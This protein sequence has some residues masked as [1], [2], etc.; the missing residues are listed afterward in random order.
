MLDDFDNED[1]IFYKYIFSWNFRQMDVL[2][3]HVEFLCLD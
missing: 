2:L 3:C 1:N